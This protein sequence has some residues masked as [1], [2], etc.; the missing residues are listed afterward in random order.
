[1]KTPA[2]ELN[3]DIDQV[4]E[5]FEFPY[6]SSQPTA[7]KHNKYCSICEAYINPVEMPG[8]LPGETDLVW[9]HRDLV[10]TDDDLK[11]FH[12]PVQ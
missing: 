4:T 8:E 10:H 2:S 12:H 11:A 3:D 6:Y 9:V 7:C 5:G 1:M